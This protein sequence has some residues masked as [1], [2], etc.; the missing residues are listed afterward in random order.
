MPE[1]APVTDH[2]ICG[3]ISGLD[4]VLVAVADLEAARQTFQRLGFTVTP[5]GR[6]IGWGTGNYCIMFP[7]NYIELLGIVDPAQ[8]TNNLDQ[9]LAERGEGLLGLALATNDA[10]AAHQKLTAS[11]IAAEAPK[12]LSRLLELPDGTVEPRF[13]LV[14]LPPEATAGVSA[15]VC[16][17]LTR[18]MVWQAPWLTHPNGATGITEVRVLHDSPQAAARTWATLSGE[19]AIEETRDR[20]TVRHGGF[21]ITFETAAR[22][23]ML[24]TPAGPWAMTVRVRDLTLTSRTLAEGGIEVRDD[25]GLLRVAPEAACGVSLTFTQ[26]AGD[27]PPV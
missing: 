20:A 16:H 17:H 6:H 7:G 26:T 3:G 8:F 11:G 12:D 1:A 14:H 2:G 9:R 18:D 10:D 13:K 22:V 15:F 27:S 19:A 5:R 21:A 23:E 25:D 4:H 24:G